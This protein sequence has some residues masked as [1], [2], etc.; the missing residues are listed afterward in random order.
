MPKAIQESHDYIMKR[1]LDSSQSKI[2]GQERL[3]FPQTKSMY[4]VPTHITIKVLP[5]LTK[6]IQMVGFLKP[7]DLQYGEHYLIYDAS[8]FQVHGVTE[9][10]YSGFGLSSDIVFGAESSTEFSLDLIFKDLVEQLANKPE[11]FDLLY[12]SGTAEGQGIETVLDST[13]IP[14][15]FIQPY[16]AEN[17]GKKYN[18]SSQT[19][20]ND[21]MRISF[22]ESLMQKL[23]RR[24]KVRVQLVEET[25]IGEQLLHTIFIREIPEN[26]EEFLANRMM[27]ESVMK[28]KREMKFSN[29]MTMRH[30]IKE[31]IREEMD[32][33]QSRSRGNNQQF[34]EDKQDIEDQKTIR[35]F[36]QIIL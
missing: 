8:N 33:K 31:E 14:Q 3:V 21:E 7:I 2:L 5:N 11:N 18:I 27:T 1:F 29:Q 36:K 6:G 35:D 28:K 16:Q 9:S 30:D 22:N 24:T 15:I 26:E 25:I 19:M 20:I 32:S 4:V 10:L 23:F 13:L 34:Q 12:K 17:D